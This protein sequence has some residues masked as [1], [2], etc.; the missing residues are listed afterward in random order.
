MHGHARAAHDSLS[1]YQHF[2][3]NI[4]HSGVNMTLITLVYVSMDLGLI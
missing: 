3:I 1:T 4:L 2:Q